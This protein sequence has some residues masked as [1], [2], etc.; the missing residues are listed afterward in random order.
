MKVKDLIMGLI[1]ENPD[2]EVKCVTYENKD[3]DAKEFL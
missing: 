2:A 3:V 1:Y